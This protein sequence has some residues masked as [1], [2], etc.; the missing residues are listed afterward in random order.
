MDLVGISLIIIALAFV[1]LV[2]FLI[3]VLKKASEMIDE[4]QKSLT[5]LTSDVNV[6]L[7]QTNGILAKANVFAEDVNGKLATIAPLFVAIADLS[8]SVSDL[9]L[10]ARQFGQKATS[11]TSNMTKVGKV[12]L[13][14]KIVSTLFGRKGEKS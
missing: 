8:E 2:I 10:Q 12:A 1:A 6:I 11:A 14:S 9:N 3:V 4:A 5:V 7:H 13:I